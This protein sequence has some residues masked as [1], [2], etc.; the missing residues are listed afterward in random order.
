MPVSSSSSAVM[1]LID[2]LRMVEFAISFV[3]INDLIPRCCETTP[4]WKASVHGESMKVQNPDGRI[5]VW[6]R[7]MMKH[8]GKFTVSCTGNTTKCAVQTLLYI[9]TTY[10][11]VF[12]VSFLPF[13]MLSFL[14]NSAKSSNM[15]TATC[16]NIPLQLEPYSARVHYR[17]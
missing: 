13:L 4:F 10:K 7:E 1:W 5:L 11:C 17:V 2:L 15:F 8:C 3:N 6:L 16:S 9:G 14:A 12:A